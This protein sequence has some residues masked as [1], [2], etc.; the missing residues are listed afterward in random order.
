M[1]RRA[2]PLLSRHYRVYALLRKPDAPLAALF[3]R[4]GVTPIFGDLDRPETLRRLAGLAHLVLHFAP[5]PSSGTG[6]PRTGHLIA[7]LKRGKILPRRLVYISTSGIYGDCRGALIDETRL[8]RPQ[9]ARAQRR[10]AAEEQLRRWGRTPGAPTISILRA[11]G[12]Y[13]ADRLPLERIR[14]GDP[15]LNREDDVYTNHIHADDLA[16]S[17]IAALRRGRPNR[18]YHASDDSESGMADWFA[19]VAAAFG[20]PPPPRVARGE[21]EALLSPAVL[22]FMAESRRLDNNRLKRELGVR[23]VHP[24]IAAGLAAAREES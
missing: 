9:T 11:P 15:V 21:A 12:I 16:R 5:P 14:R 17:S 8:V 22:S 7:A 10:V 4:Y 19:A 18:A 3:C 6:D 1:A 2:L 23:L 13:A 20:L 24:N